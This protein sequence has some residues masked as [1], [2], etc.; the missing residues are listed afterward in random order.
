MLGDMLLMISHGELCHS[1]CMHGDSLLVSEI[2]ALFSD[3]EEA[4]TRIMLHAH[5]A[6]SDFRTVVIK[7]PDTDVF[8]LAL[9]MAHEFHDC[10][11]LFLTGTRNLRRIIVSKLALKHGRRKCKSILSLHVFTGC[12]SVSALKG[13]GKIKPLEL[14]FNTEEFCDSFG[15]LGCDWDDFELTLPA[16]EKFVCHLYGQKSCTDV[17]TARYNMYRLTCRSDQSLPPNQDCLRN[18]LKQ[19]NYQACIH[20]HCLEQYIH[21]PSPVGYGWK[22]DGANNL[23]Y[24]WMCDE[25]APQSVLKSV[26]C[27]CQKSGCKGACS[28]R[29]IGLP[30]TDL[31][32]CLL[33][34][35]TNRKTTQNDPEFDPDSD[36]DDEDD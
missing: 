28:C 8:V 9:S 13:V 21:A 36:I 25:P 26:H 4:D 29:K 22:L 3:H 35:C 12:D 30:C 18:H 27:S 10:D 33:L 32:R 19:A 1:L 11:L 14:M 5:H 24:D 31:C 2:P 20:R 6:A 17:N 16:I 34:Q 7:S 23:I 15:V